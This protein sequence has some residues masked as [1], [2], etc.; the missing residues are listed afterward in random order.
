MKYSSTNLNEPGIPIPLPWPTKLI[1]E[2]KPN[3]VLSDYAPMTY[4]TDPE[5][6]ADKIVKEKGWD[7]LPGFQPT[8]VWVDLAM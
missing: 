1:V 8:D 4:T 2:Y 3:G 6:E 5:A 7:L